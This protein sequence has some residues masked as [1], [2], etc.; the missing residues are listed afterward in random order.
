MPLNK[1]SR[2]KRKLKPV[3]LLKQKGACYWC[4]ENM[5]VETVQPLSRR[6]ATF[7]HITP[8]SLGG[9]DHQSNLV[10]ACFACNQAHRPGLTVSAN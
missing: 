8:T 4:G 1:N 2:R 3:L 9:T 6:A 7:E 5:T 10:M